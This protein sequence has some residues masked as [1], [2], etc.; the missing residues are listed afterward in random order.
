MK[1]IKRNRSDNYIAPVV[2][3]AAGIAGTANM[4][5]AHADVTTDTGD[6]ITTHTGWDR[7]HQSGAVSSATSALSSARSD[8]TSRAS[9]RESSVTSAAPVA[10]GEQKI[11]WIDVYVD[12]SNLDDALQ[13]ATMRGVNVTHDPTVVRIGD[14]SATAKNNSEA[15]SYY[16]SKA[17]EAR[18]TADKYVKDIA[19]Y[20]A[21]V[22]KNRQD[23]I[24]AN[25]QMN[26]LRSNLA[27]QGQTTSMV[28]KQY[29]DQDLAND[30]KQIQESIADGK[31]Y[32]IAK[33][34]TRRAQT[35]QD[36]MTLFVSEEAA[37]QCKLT[38][39]DVTIANEQDAEN[40]INQLN[41]ELQQLQ[42]YVNGLPSQTGTIPE[43][44]RPTYTLYNFR[45]DPEIE[46]KGTAVVPTYHYLPIPVTKP[47]V[48]NVNYHIYDIRD[49][50]TAKESWDNADGEVI[51]LDQNLN[52]GGRVV[53]QA[54]VNQ[55]VGIDTDRQPLPSQRFDKIED[56]TIVTKIPEGA[57]F[58]KEMSNT[59]PANWI[60]TY[61]EASHTVRQTATP[62]YLVQ[63]NLNQDVNNRGSVGGTTDGEWHYHA[64]QIFFKLN[65]DNWTYQTHS[66]TI[67]N[68]EYQYVGSDIQIRTD[69]ADPA[70]ANTNSK[71]QLIDGKAVLPGSINNYI[72][73]WDFN[74]YKNV[75]IDREM[76]KKGLVLVDDY[77]EEAV[78]LTGPISVV[79]P[80]NG[81]VLYSAKL[82][83]NNSNTQ[84]TIKVGATGTFQD[85]SGKNVDGF[86]WTVIDK[87]NAPDELKEKLKGKAIMIKYVGYDNAFYKKYV[88]GGIQL[89]V[90]F[91]M[92]TLKIDNT[93]DKQGGTYNGNHY[94]NV[95]YQSDFGNDYKSNTVENDAPLLDP[96][97]DVVVSYGNLTSL[98]LNK[99]PQATIEHQDHFNY[100]LNGSTLPTNL[101]ENIFDYRFTDSFD[102]TADRYDG[103]FIVQTDTDIHFKK[104]STLLDRYPDGI[105]AGSDISKYFTQTVDR[106][107]N[108]TNVGHITLSADRDFLDQID[109][110]KTNMHFEAFLN[111]KRIAN[112]NGVKNVF[113]ENINNIDYGSN[114]VITNSRRNSIDV[115]NDQL[116][117][118]ESSA[119]S[120]ISS[121]ASGIASNAS[122][123]SS[124][125][126]STASALSIIIKT[127]T[128]VRD[129]ASSAISSAV[130]HADQQNSSVA[131]SA[132]SAIAQTASSLS[133]GISSVASSAANKFTSADY[134]QSMNEHKASSVASEVSSALS[135]LTSSAASAIG[136]LAI[137]FERAT[138]QTNA[139]LVIYDQNI[140]ND[141]D[142]LEYAINDGV[143]AGSIRQIRRDNQGHYVVIYN[144]SQTAIN[145]SVKLP[146]KAGAIGDV[147]DKTPNIV[148][149]SV[150]TSVTTTATPVQT[151]SPVVNRPTASYTFY[152]LKTP[153]EVYQELAK[154]GYGI[155]DVKTLTQNGTVFTAIVY[156]K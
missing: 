38:H 31:R 68:K 47:V 96:R 26:A 40:Y 142:A 115:L 119:S 2:I 28:S 65:K 133:S 138:Q 55:T 37:G 135:S 59:D 69:Q 72:V 79:N 48:P 78:S 8:I 39:Q 123:I 155:N 9:S 109:I 82:P 108:E 152:L 12:H 139:Q 46:K 25:D 5:V 6:D 146:V 63:V 116:K 92:T 54:M 4:Q 129:S 88:E 91:P 41:N 81:Q 56:L 140:D 122:A 75:N 150:S 34:A 15:T 147:T 151:P 102:T 112:K 19:N 13:Y 16:K 125:A 76:Q 86:T 121:N 7:Q 77:P 84:G 90:L 51:V 3:L 53:A 62:E 113:D 21:Q 107:A 74:Q 70:K 20:H 153:A 89:D 127:I 94:S 33:Q 136:N 66:T 10:S 22:Q 64:P 35:A 60:L 110:S 73:G 98:D 45:V 130:S 103:E 128:S 145:G 50:M 49:Q 149:P 36:A 61:D 17:A 131:S 67:V 156:A 105:K 43:S 154:Y 124:Q 83:A 87:S 117:S 111:M 99:N 14:A 80:A 29:S 30:T 148:S 18:S 132:S 134:R 95:A 52:A 71:Y 118:L 44:Q 143:A 106:T 24:N 57:T 97:K 11:G 85:A 93:P 100:R 114:E 101:S 137:R 23:A 120:N 1:K 104:D 58:N 27:A 141:A 126:S 144:D 32:L 42:H